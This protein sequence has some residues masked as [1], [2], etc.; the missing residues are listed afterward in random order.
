M[1]T[2]NFST[3]PPPLTDSCPICFS[4]NTNIS[5]TGNISDK[6]VVHTQG[7]GHLH[8]IHG[9]CLRAW[10]KAITGDTVECFFCKLPISKRSIQKLLIGVG[11][12]TGERIGAYIDKII[13][14]WTP[15]DSINF[16]APMIAACC[17][18]FA[19]IL[20]GFVSTYYDAESTFYDAES[21]F[22]SDSDQTDE[23][24]RHII[25]LRRHINEMKKPLGNTQTAL[26]V[27][28]GSLSMMSYILALIGLNY[29]NAFVSLG[30]K[31]GEVFDYVIDKAGRNF[32]LNG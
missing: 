8:P 14:L 13:S 19:L 11:E 9:K 7:Q 6:Y 18:G 28:G 1:S 15:E 3:D 5:D 32:V 27:S 30:R 21:T 26:F 16:K 20:T 17:L 23:I 10:A 31:I 12:R 25:E 2:I 24:N 22:P 29:P 4:S